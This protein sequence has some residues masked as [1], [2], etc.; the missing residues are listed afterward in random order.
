[1]AFFRLGS[2]PV[3]MIHGYAFTASTTDLCESRPQS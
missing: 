2:A 1:M 3:C